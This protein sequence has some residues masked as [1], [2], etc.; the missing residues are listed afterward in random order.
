M[1]PIR[2]RQGNEFEIPGIPVSEAAAARIDPIA[3]LIA[4]PDPDWRT[5]RE[6][7]DNDEAF[8]V[9]QVVMSVPRGRPIDVSVGA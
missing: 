5:L 6:V 9:P 1:G 4:D 2:E 3:A 7:Y 8:R